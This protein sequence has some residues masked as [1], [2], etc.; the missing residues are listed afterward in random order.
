MEKGIVNVWIYAR[1][2]GLGVCVL[3]AELLGGCSICVEHFVGRMDGM[4]RRTGT[5]D[6][7]DRN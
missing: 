3:V 2:W 6:G 1:D 7:M 4:V 5:I